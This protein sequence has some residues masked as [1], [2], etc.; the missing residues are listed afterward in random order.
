M[1]KTISLIVAWI[2]VVILISC[3]AWHLKVKDDL[4]KAE[5]YAAQQRWDAAKEAYKKV[6]S[7]DATHLRANLMIGRIAYRQGAFYEAIEYLN[8]VPSDVC[9]ATLTLGWCYDAIGDRGK[10]IEAY[11][12]TLRLDP[13]E[14]VA[15]AARLGLETPHSPT[16]KVKRDESVNDVEV[17][18]VGWKAVADPNP[19]GASKAFDRNPKTRWASMVPQSPGM[20]YQIDLGTTKVV[21]RVVLN[22]D[23]SGTTIYVSDY[24]R[25]YTVAVS[26]DGEQWKVVASEV[27]DLNSYAGAFFEPTEARYIKITQQGSTAPEWWSIYEVFVYSPAN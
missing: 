5:N 7:K 12:R 27:G 17:P 15:T 14:S 8:K 22:D 18:T 19:E 23:A 2:G 25:K 16:K 13:Q 9:W 24:P 20:A 1:K 26:P 10:A 6:L 21:N 3:A 11:E 4:E